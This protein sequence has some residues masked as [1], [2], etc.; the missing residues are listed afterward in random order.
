MKKLFKFYIVLFFFSCSNYNDRIE[1]TSQ[2]N[3]EGIIGY[4]KA[5]ALVKD[6]ATKIN[7]PKSK[8]F[9]F[10]D[11][12][13]QK[14]EKES[15]PIKFA[16]LQKL[17]LTKSV[18]INL[19]E[20]VDIYTFQFEKNGKQGF[21]MVTDDPRSS[22]VLAYVEEGSI[23]DTVNS[24][25]AAFVLNRVKDAIIS[26]LNIYYSD[27]LETKVPTKVIYNHWSLGPTLTTKWVCDA[28]YNNSY[29]YPNGTTCTSTTNG[30]YPASY[31]AVALAQCIAGYPSDPIL[32]Y[33]LPITLTNKYNVRA[34]AST[35]KITSSSPYATKVARFIREFDDIVPIGGFSTF[36]CGGVG[37]KTELRHAHM[38]LNNVGLTNDYFRYSGVNT[39]YK[40]LVEY[41]V[42]A[43]RLDCSSVVA[44]YNSNLTK[45]SVWIIDGI[46]GLVAADYSDYSK[47]LFIHCNFMLGGNFD[48][49]YKNFQSPINHNGNH[50]LGG[51]SSYY[52]EAITFRPVSPYID[53]QF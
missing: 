23:A 38:G 35:Q 3:N 30:K 39:P 32:K 10:S 47:D 33:D 28:P 16:N 51:D 31:T 44:G 24:S 17:I 2:S 20:S 8:A 27:K 45:Y 26:D 18:D 14:I 52:L 53:P 36:Q 25:A 42:K 40:K 5:L 13:I 12:K 41:F 19:K 21:V 37:T 15:M 43:L 34:F 22:T 49:W 48:G 9:R 4:E 7:T 11:L 50:V 1:E 6:F 29:H 46:A